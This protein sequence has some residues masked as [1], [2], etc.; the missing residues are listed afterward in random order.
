MELDELV[1]KVNSTQVKD[2]NDLI[3]EL[4]L[5]I[6]ALDKKVVESQKKQAQVGSP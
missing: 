5:N 6:Q 2:A 4:G 3:K 1:F